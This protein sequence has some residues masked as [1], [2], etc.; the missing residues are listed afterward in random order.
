M[1]RGLFLAPS[2]RALE[3]RLLAWLHEDRLAVRADASRQFRPL[4]IVVPSVSVR[5]HL[6]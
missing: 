6:C 3:A 5:A 4:R 2:A 1:A